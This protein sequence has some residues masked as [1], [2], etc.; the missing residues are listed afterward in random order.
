[1]SE[2]KCVRA[3]VRFEAERTPSAEPP[4]RG[5]AGAAEV[6]QWWR[7]SHHH[8]TSAGLC[9]FSRSVHARSVHARPVHARS[10]HARSVHA[11]SVHARSGPSLL[12]PR[13]LESSTRLSLVHAQLGPRS[14][15]PRSLGPRSAR[16]RSL[17]P[18]S[19]R[20]RSLGPRS[21]GPRTQSR[22]PSTIRAAEK[23]PASRFRCGWLT[24]SARQGNCPA[25]LYWAI[26]RFSI[27]SSLSQDE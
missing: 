22:A 21:P 16:P 14:A 25:R 17:C 9:G 13:L 20:P 7:P 24:G 4:A 12:S 10:A 23:L 26:T 27:T 19:A 1:M 3:L 15:R 11:R 2:S 18:R 6:R 8:R 5:L